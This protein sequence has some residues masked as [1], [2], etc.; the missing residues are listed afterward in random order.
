MFPW[1][2]SVYRITFLNILFTSSHT[3]I[4]HFKNAVLQ[5]AINDK[6]R[7]QQIIWKLYFNLTL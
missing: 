2:M 5:K 3:D 6:L 1:S 4:K 7:V